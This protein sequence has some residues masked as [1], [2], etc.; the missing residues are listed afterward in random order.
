[1]RVLM[2]GA[3]GV[4]GRRAIPLLLAKGHAVT[5]LT[6]NAAVG[7]SGR[8]GARV[9]VADLFDVEALKRAAADHDV[10]INLATHMPSLP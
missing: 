5:V 7:P 6:R 8:D 10:L 1:M 9:V 4:I 3:T 2:S